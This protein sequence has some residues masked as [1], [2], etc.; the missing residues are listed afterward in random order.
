MSRSSR[1]AKAPENHRAEANRPS[2]ELH[3]EAHQADES[4]DEET[5]GQR[6]PGRSAAKPID[7]MAMT[8]RGNCEETSA[9]LPNRFVPRATYLRPEQ[10]RRSP[11]EPPAGR[12]GT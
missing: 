1:R 8:P 11:G 2:H 9:Q 10:L 6:R 7:W 3:Q 5:A 12:P 4:G